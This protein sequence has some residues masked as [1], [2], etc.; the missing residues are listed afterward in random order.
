MIS[1]TKRLFKSKEQ[2]T[3]EEISILLKGTFGTELGK[4]TIEY[5]AE[6]F[7][8][9]DIYTN[10]MTLDQVAFRQGEASVIK[11]IIKEINS[12]GRFTITD[13]TK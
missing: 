7:V 13:D 2:K 11:K 10:G 1:F 4:R 12:N 3:A 6:V 9:R 8:D 5:L